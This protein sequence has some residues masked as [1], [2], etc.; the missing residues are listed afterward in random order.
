MFSAS[1][2]FT[3]LSFDI[4][5]QGVKIGNATATN[6]YLNQGPNNVIVYGNYTRPENKEVERSFMSSY[7][8]G[9]H[10]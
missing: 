2:W 4:F 10:F 7:L 8:Q 1:L 9:I 5:Y 3:R 6:L